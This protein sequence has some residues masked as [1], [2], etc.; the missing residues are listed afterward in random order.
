MLENADGLRAIAGL[1]QM[2]NDMLRQRV[3]AI[4]GNCA[5]SGMLRMK[6]SNMHRNMSKIYNPE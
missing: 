2:G 6:P 5:D 4:V 1:L 3:A